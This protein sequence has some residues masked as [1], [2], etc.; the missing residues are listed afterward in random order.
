MLLQRSRNL[1]QRHK[2]QI[3]IL[4]SGFT[5]DHCSNIYLEDILELFLRPLSFVLGFLF[6]DFP[7][8]VSCALLAR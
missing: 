2:L 1:G 7:L 5:Q 8:S 6:M 4:V 3:W